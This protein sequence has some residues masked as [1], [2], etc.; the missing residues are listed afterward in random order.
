M[1]VTHL[2]P[3]GTFPVFSLFQVATEALAVGMAVLILLD[4]VRVV[5]GQNF[6]MRL[7]RP[8]KLD[9]SKTCPSFEGTC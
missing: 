6:E 3:R 9:P 4:I 2:D 7:A 1:A 8:C 5:L